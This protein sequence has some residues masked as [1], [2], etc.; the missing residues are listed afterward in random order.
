MICILKGKTSDIRQVI[1]ILKGKTSDIRPVIC[2]PVVRYPFRV[3]M[4]LVSPKSLFVDLIFLR[5]A[6]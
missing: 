2:S 5:G 3:N 4:V 6:D 1:C